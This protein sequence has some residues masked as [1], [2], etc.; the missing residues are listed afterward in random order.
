MTRLALAA[1]LFAQAAPADPPTLMTKRGAPLFEDGFDGPALAKEWTGNKGRWLIEDGRLK[2]AEIAADM[3]HPARGRKVEHRDVVLQLRFR[4]QGAKWLGVGFDH[5]E[6]VCRAIVTPTSFRVQK[7]IGM[8]PTTKTTKL[9]EKKMSFDP[10][11][12]YTLVVELAGNEIVA[13]VDGRHVAVGEADGLDVDKTRIALIS[14]GEWAWFDDVKMWKAERDPA[15][16]QR[17]E[18]L[19]RKP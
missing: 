18:A 8:G 10:D 11:Q 3:H 6:H 7:T 5:K 1:L 19:S 13:S 14:G 9:D 4:L 12:W 16:A 17:K 2:A 15:W